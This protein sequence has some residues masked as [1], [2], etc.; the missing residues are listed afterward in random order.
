MQY[1]GQY[2]LGSYGQPWQYACLL[3]DVAQDFTWTMAV[4]AVA[5]HDMLQGTTVQY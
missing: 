1:K 3:W 2:M 4:R 5:V